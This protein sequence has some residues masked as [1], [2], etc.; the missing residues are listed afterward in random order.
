M[1]CR[2]LTIATLAL[3]ATA[4]AT[5]QKPD[6]GAF[7]I[8]LGKDTLAI[9]R[10]VRTPQ[11]LISEVAYRV[12]QTR[13]MQITITY[14]PDGNV[15]WYEA[16]NNKV[17]GVPNA[18]PM[19]RTLVTYI[20]DSAQVQTWVDAVARSP[21]SIKARADAVPLSIPFYA[22][23]DAALRHARKLGKDSSAIAVL[24]GN[25]PTFYPVKLVTA[26]SLVMLMPGSGPVF[27]KTD[28]NGGIVR[29]DGSQTTFKVV[30]TRTKW[31]D[32]A[33]WLKRW[34]TADSAG[35]S[36]GMLSPR[37]TIDLA[38]GTTGVLIDYS[39]PSMRGRK[40]FGNIVPWNQVWRTGAN[41][42][43]QVEFDGDVE[44][45]G[46]SIPKGKY[47]IW[48]LPGE[49]EWQL[50]IN[51]Q[52]GQW[53]TVYDDKQDLVRIPLKT[54]VLT[55]P[56]EEFTI[57]LDPSGLFSLSWERTRAVARIREKKN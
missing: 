43:T 37:D 8:R 17:P 24:G 14:K 20:G 31:P 19:A 32:L 4:P 42:A 55:R 52:T 33:P 45:N 36:L 21:R 16:V 48:T 10:F 44:I 49:K 30:V 54:E 11:Q 41:A 18:A 39:R 40:I 13:A 53:G 12:P 38:I 1:I 9:E 2:A 27:V 6:S 47:T 50:I 3:T 56:V 7:V 57:S 22:T 51:K 28:A 15:S 34:A 46:V 29:L 26:D 5:A 23:F 35:K 25:T